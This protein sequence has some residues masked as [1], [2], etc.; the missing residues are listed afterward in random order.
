[1]FSLKEK[2]VSHSPLSNFVMNYS[3]GE[4]KKVYKKVLNS[5]SEAQNQVLQMARSA[6]R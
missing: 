4:K 5:A 6:A 3:S 1:M 2:K